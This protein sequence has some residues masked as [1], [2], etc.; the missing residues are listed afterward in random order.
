MR[1]YPRAVYEDNEELDLV[2]PI[3][4]QA[5]PL[6][7]ALHKEITRKQIFGMTDASV[8]AND[9]LQEEDGFW[10]D[11]GWPQMEMDPAALQST[12]TLEIHS[13]IFPKDLSL[14]TFGEP[15][16]GSLAHEAW[17]VTEDSSFK[18]Q[19]FSREELH[20]WLGVVGIESVYHF[21]PSPLAVSSPIE[22]P[23]SNRISIQWPAHETKNLSA[24]RAAAFIWEKNYKKGDDTTAPTNEEISRFLQGE[25]G[26]AP[27]LADS[28]ATILRADD[29][30][31]GPRTG[32]KKK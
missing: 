8:T 28:M 23:T 22:S 9:R 16:M 5:E 1:F 24:L 27:T 20:R 21:G 30:K 13:E 17:R 6:P 15:P 4:D 12:A 10:Q 25:H 11:L 2:L 14:E 31:T 18:E 7:P 26:I 29:L 19:K 32:P 3:S